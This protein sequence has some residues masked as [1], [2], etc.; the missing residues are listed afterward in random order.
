MK[1]WA[2]TL[3]AD[4]E[5]V[6]DG[7]DFNAEAFARREAIEAQH[8]YAVGYEIMLDVEGD[9]SVFVR[10]TQTKL[11]E[12]LEAKR[13]PVRGTEGLLVWVWHDAR[14]H[15]FSGPRF[16]ALLDRLAGPAIALPPA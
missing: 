12:H 10:E 2:A 16:Q 7:P 15:L 9:Q 6:V 14:A 3:L 11:Q 8:G 4:A 5:A 13:L 1:L